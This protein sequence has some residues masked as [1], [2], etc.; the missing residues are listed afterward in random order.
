[1]SDSIAVNS[2]RIVIATMISGSPQTTVAD[3]SQKSRAAYMRG[4]VHQPPAPARLRSAQDRA[5]TRC[6]NFMAAAI[7]QNRVDFES[8]GA[9]A[10]ITI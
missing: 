2:L 5:P 6:V 10:A 1:M 8:A 7:R 3:E 9:L 4:Q